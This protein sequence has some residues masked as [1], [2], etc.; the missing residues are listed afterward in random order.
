MPALVRRTLPGNDEPVTDYAPEL[1]RITARARSGDR[2][3]LGTLKETGRRLGQAV[4]VVADLVDPRVVVL[5]GA[6]ATLSPWLLPAAEAELSTRALIVSEAGT[7]IV[8]SKLEPGS[9]AAGG[10]ALALD[11]LEAGHLPTPS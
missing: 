10:A 3:V 1:E 6:F 5:G 9:A 11:R 2:I 8:V 7:R 4:S